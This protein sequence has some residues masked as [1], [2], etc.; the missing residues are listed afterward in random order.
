MWVEGELDAL[1]ARRVLTGQRPRNKPAQGNALG[2]RFSADAALKGR[3]LSVAK[4]WFAPTGLYASDASSQGVAL[5]TGLWAHLWCFA[6]SPLDPHSIT[7][8]ERNTRLWQSMM[9]RAPQFLPSRAVAV[10][11]AR[12]ATVFRRRCGFR[13]FF[14]SSGGVSVAASTRS[15][16]F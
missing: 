15:V 14:A 10:S 8:E 6:T 11:K 13:Y 1:G 4:W 2:K 5:G 9:R 3:D 12:M 16:S 7:P